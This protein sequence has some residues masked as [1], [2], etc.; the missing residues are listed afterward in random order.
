[1]KLGGYK[2]SIIRVN[3]S[4]Y[5]YSIEPLNEKMILDFIGGRGFAIKLLYDELKPGIDP[6]SEQNKLIFVAG[7][8]AGTNAQSFGRWK[9]FFKSPLTGTYF[10]SSG[11]G[12]LVAEMKFAGFDIIIIEGVSEKPVY[13]WIYDGKCEFKDATYLMGLDCDDTHTLIREELGDPRIRIAC[14]GPAG[15]NKV[16]ISGIF[17]DRRAAARGGG[18]AVMG[19]KNLKA[20][21]IRGHEKVEIADPEGFSEAVKAQIQTYKSNPAFEGFRARGTQIA[22][23]TNLLGMFPTKN[24]R[25]GV[26]EGWENI[27]GQEYDK[28]RVRKTG[29]HSCMLHCGNLSKVNYGKYKGAWSEGPEYES[30]WAFTGTIS[31]PDVGL[32][33]A[34]DKLCDDLGLDTISTGS[35]I[36]FA[37]ELYEKGII[38]KDDT[39]GLELIYGNDE[40]LVKLIKQIAYR[41]GFGDILADGTREAAKKIGKGAE[42]YAIQVK[43]LE[44]PAY[45]PRGAKSHGLNLLTSNIGAD[46]NSGYAPQEIFNV[47]IPRPVDRF[48]VEGKG[49]ITKFNQDLTAFLETGILCSFPPSMGMINAEVYGKLVSTVTGIKD[50]DDPEYIWL[51]GERIYNLERIFNVREG[52]SKKDDSFPSRLISEPLPSGPASGQI[53]EQDDLLKDYYKVRGWDLETGV[54]TKD[55]LKELGLDFALEYGK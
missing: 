42:K 21:A 37:Y 16:K 6:M 15:E 35:S 44:L 19:S 1:M 48:A 25:E 29:C 5:T 52:F 7:P 2:N 46:H 43:G 50:F 17:S 51:V 23:F 38:S 33:I 39:G 47:P 31:L 45:D 36:G 20:I 13:L 10:K 40:P 3:L 8:L 26:I 27:E 12:Y 30:I 53:F 49:E 9:V 54:P 55:K 32:T 24:F 22:E 28:Y 34:L 18:G 41:E 14:I 4:N 11:G